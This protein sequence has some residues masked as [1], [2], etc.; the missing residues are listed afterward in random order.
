MERRRLTRGIG[1]MALAVLALGVI[2]YA[3]RPGGGGP[4]AVPPVHTVDG[5]QR[6]D[7]DVLASIE[8]ALGREPQGRTV[9]GTG[10]LT[11][12]PPAAGKEAEVARQ[13]AGAAPPAPVSGAGTAQGAPASSLEDRKIVQTAAIRLQVKDVAAGFAEVGRIA[14]SAGGFVAGS[15]FAL[16]GEAQVASITIRVPAARYQEVLGE[17][18]RLGVKVESESSNASDVTEEYS[19]LSARLRTLEATENQLL[20]L[21]GRAQNV[22]EVLQVQ[23]RLNSVRAEIERVKG[24]MSLLDRLTDLATINVQLRPLLPTKAASDRVDIGAEVREAWEASLDFL[25]SIAA[26]V[27]TVL[28]FGWW[29]VLLGVPA[30]IIAS[31]WLRGRP[32][33]IEAVD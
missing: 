29:V 12:P 27:L 1:L 23:D 32:R 13:N 9:E 21:L 4:V 5:E 3:L 18:R 11:I 6:P 8:R 31:R 30:A 10:A 20:Q 28:V 22:G 26:G 33:P 7:G 24:R 25:A 2:G 19:D 15:S 17:L 14:T 16:Q